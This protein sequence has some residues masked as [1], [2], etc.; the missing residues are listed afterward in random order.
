MCLFAALAAAW[1]S[2]ALAVP[3]AA[4][5]G[6]FLALELPALRL[7][8]R[9]LLAMA[10]CAFVIALAFAPDPQ[11]LLWRAAERAAY[12]G[13]FI[14]LLS[15]LRAAAMTSQSVLEVGRFLTRQP[16]GRRYIAIAA[17]GHAMG[18][19]LNF[20]ALSLLAPLV[21][22]GARASAG[23]DGAALT[24]L[25]E[26]RQLSALARGFSWFIL[27]APT[28]I[29]QVVAVAVV[30]GARAGAVAAAGAAV[31]FSV[32]AAGW[33][34][35]RFTGQAA[36][37]R[38]GLSG[39]SASRDAG[40]AP[41][42]EIRRLALIYVVLA[43]TA[44]SAALLTGRSLVDGIML[45]AAPATIAWIVA[46][47]M[48]GRGGDG[49]RTALTGLY[50]NALPQGSP[51]AVTLALAGFVG[52]VLAGTVP[53]EALTTHLPADSVPPLA[54]YLGVLTLIPA[55]SSLGLPPMLT[56]TFI[57]ALLSKA[58]GAA[59]DP[60]LLALSLVMGWA[61]NLTA[62]PFGATNLILARTT[63]WPVS[64]LAFSWNGRFNAIAWTICAAALAL[65]AQM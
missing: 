54:L 27:W 63:G 5:L 22:R 17:G 34:E 36:R 12:L 51:E 4:L 41:M 9:Y 52:T 64:T 8:E 10:A 42:R 28:S 37:R 53:V 13:A 3:A 39:P 25:R 47:H 62:S 11:T 57:G 2:Q 44:A 59:I 24:Q 23:A 38:L 65:L 60:N 26:Q 33:V 21:Q 49:L 7:R 18:V 55:V 30:S 29:G 48:A 56:V 61:L 50:R 1:P 32:V 19:V 40:P 15:L 45:S 46:Q 6:L 31:A 16:P 14:A 20:G 43:A 58:F 35:D